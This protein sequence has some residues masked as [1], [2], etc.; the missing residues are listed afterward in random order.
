M[1]GVGAG[2]RGATD[3]GRRAGGVG[4][5]EG[6]SAGGRSN[7]AARV[8]SH[9]VSRCHGVY[10]PSVRGSRSG[11]GVEWDVLRGDVL[12]QAVD[13][14]ITSNFAEQYASNVGN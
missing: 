11:R 8:A 6:T 2:D 13:E 4:R 3:A 9:A 7:A 1:C 10:G 5:R 12:Q 14:D